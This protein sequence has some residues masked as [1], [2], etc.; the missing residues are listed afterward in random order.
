MSLFSHQGSPIP[1]EAG[2]GLRAEHYQEIITTQ[3][4]IGWL[5]VHSENYFGEGGL[6][7]YYLKRIRDNY[8]LSL[9]GVGLSLGSTD[10]LNVEHLGKLKKLITEFEPGLVSEHLCWSSI[11][12]HYLNDLLPIPYTEEALRLMIEHIN[13]A[14]EFLNHQLL[15]EN[16]STYI[17][18]T[19]STIPEYEFMGE[20]VK[21]TGCGILLDINNLYV[22]S[23]NHG[24]DAGDYLAKIAPQSVLEIHLAGFVQN[25]FEGGTI[26]IDSHNQRVAVAVWKLYQQ[27][28]ECIGQRPTL[29]EWD[30]DIPALAILLDEAQKANEILGVRDVILTQ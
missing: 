1:A 22:N 19:H 17:Q 2:I 21:H 8:S 7:G 3:P 30:K 27:A 14:Q 4:P 20:L 28:V 11:G 6:P 5:E 23:V 26:L 9:H 24:W 12:G 10:N 15:I 16:I 13:Q 18:F 25:E 29:I